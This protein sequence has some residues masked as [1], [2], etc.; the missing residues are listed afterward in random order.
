MKSFAA[1]SFAASARLFAVVVLIALS[2]PIAAQ[3]AYPGKPIRMIVPFPPGG[4]N[5]IIA[6]IIGQKLTE[7]W[8]QQVLVDNRGGGNT[9]IGTDALVKS[10]PDGYTL[11][12]VSSA[13]VINPLLLANLPY[14]A[15]KDFAPVATVASAEQLLVIHPSVSANNLQEFIALAKARPGQL[16]YASSGTGGVQH[17]AGEFF[18]ILAGTKIQHI[19]YKGGGPAMTDLIGGQVQSYFSATALAIPLIATGKIK[20]LAISG[21]TRQPALPQV[22]TFTEAGLPGY[23]VKGWFAVLAPAAT[24]RDIVERLSGEIARIVA[25]PDIS[26]KLIAQGQNPFIS[27]PEQV[28]AMLKADMARYAKIIKTANIR[29]EE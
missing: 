7:S 5:T 23:E 22:P 24:P 18:N 6:R 2:A 10:A 28:A 17:L 8:G 11:I 20:A 13:H 29:I 9:I 1:S 21:E 16:N 27:T 19:P 3:Q 25:M 26:E 15:I 12:L 14:D 4:A